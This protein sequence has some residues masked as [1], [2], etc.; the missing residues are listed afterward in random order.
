LLCTVYKESPFVQYL[1]SHP[2]SLIPFP[3]KTELLWR[4]YVTSNNKMYLGL[5]V[6]FQISSSDCNQIWI[7]STYFGESPQ[8]HIS[9]KLVKWELSWYIRTDGRRQTGGWAGGHD[10]AN[11]RLSRVCEHAEKRLIQWLRENNTLLRR[12][13]ATSPTG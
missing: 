13:A 8:H 12:K 3:S 9:R 2:N 4:L 11:R 5:H 1:L 7:F 10:E 6:K